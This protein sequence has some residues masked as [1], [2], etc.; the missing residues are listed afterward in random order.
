[1][2]LRDL[3][4]RRKELGTQ[5][6]LIFKSIAEETAKMRRVDLAEFIQTGDSGKINGFELD[7]L[8]RRREHLFLLGESLDEAI[9]TEQGKVREKKV[10][11]LLRKADEHKKARKKLDD[12]MKHLLYKIQDYQNQCKEIRIEETA[13]RAEAHTDSRP[14]K[15]VNLRLNKI[16]EF[17][18][19][20]IILTPGVERIRKETQE[21]KEHNRK[22]LSQPNIGGD[23]SLFRNVKIVW[24]C[25]TL[26][27]LELDIN[28]LSAEACV[29]NL[30]RKN[31]KGEAISMSRADFFKENT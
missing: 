23:N 18:E 10:T 13:L 24:D 27:L 16:E 6:D 4:S 29:R 17:L 22:I 14:T 11:L 8:Q 1:M 30:D 7:K 21:A 12:K 5:K 31:S 3:L 15:E 20:Q 19:E 25:K 2:K 28:E 26:A 9:V